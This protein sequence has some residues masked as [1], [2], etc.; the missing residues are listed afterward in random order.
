MDSFFTHFQKQLSK[1]GKKMSQEIRFITLKNNGAFT[2][3]I[4]IKGGSDSYD[5]SKFPVKQEKTVD[6][7]DLGEK[8]KDGDIVYLEAV[9]ALGKNNTAKERFIYRKNSINNAKYSIKGTTLNNSLSFNGIKAMYTLID[10]PIKEI[11]LKNDGGFTVGIRINGGSNS[12]NT[13]TFPIG[14]EKTVDLADVGGRIKDGDEVWLEAVVKLGTNATAKEHFIYKKESNKRASYSISGTTLNNSLTYNKLDDIF[15]PTAPEPINAICLYNSGAFVAQIN[16][17]IKHS[18]GT[19]S[20]YNQ[21]ED[22]C[23]LKNKTLD[24]TKTDAKDGD[25]VLLE[26]EV[27]LG[28]NK[29]AAE[30]F[31][32]KADAK[33]TANYSINGTTLDNRLI[34]DGIESTAPTTAGEIKDIRWLT[35]EN[36][37]GFVACIRVHAEHPNGTSNS[38]N[39]KKN[40][41]LGFDRKLDLSDTDGVVKEGDIVWL[42]VVVKLGKNNKASERFIYKNDSKYN[43]SY[44]IK[45]TTLHN[46]LNFNG[47][48]IEYI[49]EDAEVRYIALKNKG[50]FVTRIRIKGVHADGSSYSYNLDKDITVLYEKT[51]DLSETNGIVRDGDYVQLEAVVVWGNNKK[52]EDKFIYKS[53]SNTIARYTIYGTTLSNTLNLTYFDVYA[54]YFECC[55]TYSKNYTSPNNVK[56]NFSND[57]QGICHDNEAWYISH[58]AGKDLFDRNHGTIHKIFIN[59]SLSKDVSAKEGPAETCTVYN[60]GILENRRISKYY[61]D[62]NDIVG[63]KV[64]DIHMGD[65]DCFNGYIFVPVYQSGTDGSADA[66]I[67]I[68]STK[69]LD[70][71][72]SEILY[73]K[74]NTP[75]HGLAWCAINPNDGC[76]YTSDS[77]IRNEFDGSNSP[78]MAFKIN[79]ENLKDR[80]GPVFTNVTPN[81]IPLKMP[82][83]STFLLKAGMQGGCFDPYDNIYLVS[84]FEEHKANDGVVAFKLNRVL[85][86]VKEK[87]IQTRAYFI[88]KEKNC[89]MQSEA[90]RQKDWNEAKWQIEGAINSGLLRFEETPKYAEAYLRQNKKGILVSAI[91]YSFDGESPNIYPE[92]PEGITYWDTRSLDKENKYNYCKSTLHVLKLT[93]NGSKLLVKDTYSLVNYNITNIDTRNIT[94]KYN[95]HSL[96]VKKNPLTNRWTIVSNGTIPVKDFKTETIANE[97]LSVLKQFYELE[98]IGDTNSTSNTIELGQALLKS[99]IQSSTSQNFASFIFEYDD[100]D[101][102]GIDLESTE[103]EN[104]EIIT[105][106]SDTYKIFWQIKFTNSAKRHIF[107]LGFYNERE[108][109]K[110]YDMAK[111]YK[112][113]CSFINVN[114]DTDNLALRWFE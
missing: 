53:T 10:E 28:K 93:N 32:F 65:I 4:R 86:S 94:I 25:L 101:I 12:Y 6:L 30:S 27:K 62:K 113:I 1:K 92:E 41:T 88:W 19:K 100:L 18:D 69:N 76:L 56:T 21:N 29:T 61:N 112:K 50:A 80:K 85:D 105:Q 11:S 2:V 48:S 81:G 13:D 75:F 36:K 22:I 83:G 20:C 84:G 91:D 24:L 90:D 38:Y 23:V 104:N 99:P 45:G 47:T 43:A 114:D 39:I 108:A 110:F 89:P 52:A 109:W 37:G 82:D 106:N 16:V 97:A 63:V 96:E 17:H 51:I 103:P 59:Q 64:G 102:F 78:L 95:P 71:I 33:K 74:T 46:S 55:Q 111:N 49:K 70:F 98:I 77:R 5:T 44:T 31:I 68:F 35:L 8:I 67:L 26:A 72:W 79:F 34:Y 60:H 73:K 66:Q 14:K 107:T 40:I 42:E 87:Y 7:A 15:P 3:G 54:N 57:I 58:G 9:V